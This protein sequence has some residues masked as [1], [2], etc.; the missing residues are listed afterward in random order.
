MH[1]YNFKRTSQK[2]SDEELISFLKA[3]WNIP[4]SDP[5]K[6]TGEFRAN[7]LN[8]HHRVYSVKSLANL[9]VLEYSL[10]DLQGKNDIPNDGIYVP[11][12]FNQTIKDSL[13]EG[14]TVLV[15]C[16]LVLSKT[17][18]RDKHE[19][20]FL[21]NADPKT[22]E[23]IEK[24]KNVDILEDDNGD[25]LIDRT[26]VNYFAEKNR[27]KIKSKQDEIQKEYES[28]AE[29]LHDLEKKN[30]DENHRFKQLLS[31]ID[32]KN[33]H[34]ESLKSETMDI[35]SEITQ[36]N[37]NKAQLEKEIAFEKE[38]QMNREEKFKNS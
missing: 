25:I 7:K 22:I 34:I 32:N 8:T 24:I 29:K 11:P 12:V 26:I 18:E 27:L 36:L 20:P 15:R 38:A 5:I 19:N 37:S 17:N 16:E 3:Q 28:E 31:D 35:K 9:E 6:I 4:Q 23:R 13:G 14:Y 1:E 33:N 2:K 21:L 10:S 30:D